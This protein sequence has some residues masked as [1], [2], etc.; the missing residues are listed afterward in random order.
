MKFKVKLFVAMLS[1]VLMISFAVFFMLAKYTKSSMREEADK[2]SFS[3]A[4]VISRL[5]ANDLLIGDIVRVKKNLDNIK[6]TNEAI[7]YIYILDEYRKVKVSTFNNKIPSGIDKWNVLNDRTPKVQL[8]ENKGEI[9]HDIG[10]NIIEGLDYELHIGVTERSI[11][12]LFKKVIKKFL[13]Y[14]TAVVIIVLIL[15]YIL[16]NFLTKPL[17]NLNLFANKLM[18]KEFGASMKTS[19]SF[20]VKRIME[21]MNKLSME[22]KEYHDNFRMNFSNLLLTEKIN[23]L[24]ILKS[25]LLHEI[26]SSITSIKLLV[27]GLDET[28]IKNDDISVIRGEAQNIEGLLKNLTGQLTA[29]DME[30]GF[31]NIVDIIENVIAEFEEILKRENIRVDF[32]PP[33]DIKY[34]KGYSNLLEHMFFN[35]MR[36]SIEAIVSDGIIRIVVV[37]RDDLLELTF[38]DT[39]CGIDSLTINKIFD[40]FFTTKKDGTGMGLYIVYNIVK[41]HYGDISVETSNG[42]TTFTIKLRGAL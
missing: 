25:G 23:A 36:N 1:I 42:E 34:F 11:E 39:G 9:I 6:T 31:L 7:V 2:L 29:S 28:N 3:L 27:S 18:N 38:S 15:S 19:G 10:V 21:V 30:I 32:V 8:L 5:I 16:S 20:E 14:I 33:E 22:L 12:T 35:L 24:N 4:Q 40:P 37:N 41:I 26:K 13:I 17:N